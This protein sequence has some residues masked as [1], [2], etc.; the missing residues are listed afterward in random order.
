M[1]TN[2]FLLVIAAYLFSCGY[3]DVAR[4]DSKFKHTMFRTPCLIVLFR[5]K[6]ILHFLFMNPTQV[7][8]SFLNQNLTYDPA[9]NI[10]LT[11]H[12]VFYHCRSVLAIQRCKVQKQVRVYY[13]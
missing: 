13:I 10:V 9:H 2:I 1:G 6:F 5:K 4:N 3:C 12:N 11:T 7:H 8:S